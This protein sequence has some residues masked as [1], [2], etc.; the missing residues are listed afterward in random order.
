M[1]RGLED[2]VT[3]PVTGRYLGQRA[4]GRV[5]LSVQAS[6]FNYCSPREGMDPQMAESFRKTPPPDGRD[7]TVYGPNHY[8]AVEIAMFDDNTGVWLVPKDLDLEGF[9]DIEFESGGPAGWVPWER[10]D[11]LIK[12]LEEWEERV[13]IWRE[14][15]WP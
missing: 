11:A 14:P 2:T 8:T 7:L 3:D 9:D 6:E 10:V 5:R 4:F 15:L 13:A 12:A 1:G